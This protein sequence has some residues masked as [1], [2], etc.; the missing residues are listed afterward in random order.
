M[1]AAA[2]PLSEFYFFVFKAKNEIRIAKV[3]RLA[4]A[5]HTPAERTPNS[6]IKFSFIF[7]ML[8]L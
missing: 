6:S 2:K 3:A 8:Y 1:V 5:I 4:M 7:R